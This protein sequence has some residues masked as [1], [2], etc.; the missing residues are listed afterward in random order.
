MLPQEKIIERLT[1]LCRADERL[2]AAMLYGSFGDGDGDAYSDVDV[3]LYFEGEQAATIHQRAWVEQIMP[4]EIYY[5]NE[6]GNGAAV[7]ENLVRAE[8]HFHPAARMSDLLQYRPIVGFRRPERAVLLDRS[9]ELSTVIARMADG[10]AS[11][12]TKAD[13]EFL[14][15]GHCNW[16]LFGTNVLARGNPA[17]AL[18]ILHVVQDHLLQM[19]RLVEGVEQRWINPTK[20]LEH[21]ISPAAYRRFQAVC[22]PL[23]PEALRA[24]YSAAWQW[25]L[26]LLERLATRHGAALPS[27]LIA[28]LDSRVMAASPAERL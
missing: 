10:P 17:R 23:E 12:D 16:V 24:A 9:G 25:G 3:I 14:A 22:P 6:Y 11:H 1:E 4:V 18:E 19:V 2:V 21:E 13:V 8:F 5:R 27:S 20:E 7:F 28:R 26:E 15:N